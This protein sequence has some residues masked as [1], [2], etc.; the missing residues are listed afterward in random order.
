MLILYCNMDI[1]TLLKI[2]TVISAMLPFLERKKKSKFQILLGFLPVI[3]LSF[4]NILSA[5]A[6]I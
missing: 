2:F 3:P 1:L 5:E 4:I 6:K